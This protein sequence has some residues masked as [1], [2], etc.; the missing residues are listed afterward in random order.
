MRDT[1]IARERGVERPEMVRLAPDPAG[2][3]RHLRPP[4]HSD[5]DP[6]GHGGETDRR[7]GRRFQFRGNPAWGGRQSG[8]GSAALSPEHREENEDAMRHEF[9]MP[10]YTKIEG[11]SLYTH[12]LECAVEIEPDE[13]TG[14]ADWYIARCF[15]EH[16]ARHGLEWRKL[17]N[18]HGLFDTITRW[19]LDEYKPQIEALWEDYLDDKPKRRARTD[20]QEHATHG[21]VL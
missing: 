6:V 21:G 16:R 19:A 4:T 10:G 11:D 2:G 14:D 7:D 13:G 1:G 15:I 3:W 20:R 8:K 18:S 17:S 12:D 5:R 9:T